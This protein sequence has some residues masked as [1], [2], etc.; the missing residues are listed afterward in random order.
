MVQDTDQF[1]RAIEKLHQRGSCEERGISS[2][3][4]DCRYSHIKA[5]QGRRL[6]EVPAEILI[7]C[8]FQ[9][10]EMARSWD[11]SEKHGFFRGIGDMILEFLMTPV[12]YFTFEHYHSKALKSF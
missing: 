6:R 5:L 7:D 11:Y 8:N 2:T 4:P 12:R 1:D 9:E 3:L 10:N